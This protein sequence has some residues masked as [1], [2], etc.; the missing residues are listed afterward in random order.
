MRNGVTSTVM[1][2]HDDKIVWDSGSSGDMVGSTET[3]NATMHV[4]GVNMCMVICL[5]HCGRQIPNE[6]KRT[7]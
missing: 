6:M 7:R 1:I 2:V 5:R 3:E 4:R